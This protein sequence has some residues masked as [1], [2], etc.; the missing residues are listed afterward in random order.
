MT[1]AAENLSWKIGQKIIVDDVT[2]SAVPGKMLGLLGPNGS[3]N[4]R[5]CACW[6]GC[7]KPM[8][9]G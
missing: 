4:P 8:R 3:G 5:C 1:I 2:I 7:A 6:Q 9:G